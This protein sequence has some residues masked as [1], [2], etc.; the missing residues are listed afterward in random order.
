MLLP[1]KSLK[2]NCKSQPFKI[3][4]NLFFEDKTTKI[5]VLQAKISSLDIKVA[6]NIVK[7]IQCMI[8]TILKVYLIPN[9]Q[10]NLIFFYLKFPV[11]EQ[12]SL[13]TYFL[14]V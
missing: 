2:T 4:G 13:F 8:Y 10:K 6:L 7:I 11:M 1:D 3:I 5:N 9:F 12:I 14:S